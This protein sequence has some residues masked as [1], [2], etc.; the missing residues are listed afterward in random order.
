MNN[1]EMTREWFSYFSLAMAII[2]FVFALLAAL[3]LRKEGKRAAP[4]QDADSRV[5]VSTLVLIVCLLAGAIFLV[6]WL[7]Y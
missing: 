5:G 7:V 1:L 3:F 6:G 2:F 4:H